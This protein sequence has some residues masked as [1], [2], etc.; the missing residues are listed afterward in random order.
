MNPF[1]DQVNVSSFTKIFGKKNHT[2]KA[3]DC[4]NFV[5]EKGFITGVLGPNGAGKSTLLKVL[6]GIIYA[7]SGNISVCGKS[8]CS[9]IRL[10][11]GYV[12]ET[13]DLDFSLSVKETLYYEA[14]LHG[15][16]KNEIS[17]SVKRVVRLLELENVLSKKNSTLSK[18]YKQRVSLAKALVFNPKVL[19]LD[20]F[21][22]GLDPAQ[23]VSVKKTIKAISKSCI[24]ILSTHHIDEAVSLCDF[25][26]ILHKGHIAIKGSQE[27][28]LEITGKK[29]I[30]E[31][32]LCFT[33]D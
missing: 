28:I 4:I 29:N 22:G 7:S 23:I 26:Y 33:K 8:E 5:A 18:G 30:E 9:E 20:E 1:E 24:T 19:I 27:E 17:E 6:S 11:T 12:P 10:I 16:K 15:M 3:C 21:S 13:P 31:A 14:L 32:F 25:I 2:V